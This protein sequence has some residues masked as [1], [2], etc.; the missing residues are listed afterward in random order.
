ML[1]GFKARAL[2]PY[3]AGSWV[4]AFAV[5]DAPARDHL[6]TLYVG[7][8]NGGVWKTVNAGTTFEPIFDGQPKLSIGDV[9]VAPSDPNVV[10]VGTGEPYCARSSNSGD[11]VWKS[12]D[13][14]KTWTNMGLGDTHHI[15]RVVIHPANPDVVYVAAM[16]HLFSEN[17]ERGVFKTADGG[18]SWKKVLYVDDRIGAV[19]LTL[20]KSAP[21]T[22][23]RGDVREGATALDLQPRRTGECHPQD[24]RRREDVDAA[25]GRPADGPDRPD[26]ARRLPEGPERALRGRRERQ[27]AAGDAAGDRAGQAPRRRAGAAHRGQRGLPHGRRRRDLA[28]GQRRLRGG[29]RQGALLLQPAEDRS[30]RQGDRLHH[31]AVPRLDQRRRQDL[32]GPRLAVRRRHAPGLRRLAGD[33]DRSA[34]PGPADL[35]FGRRRQLSPMTGARRATTPTTCR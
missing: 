27:P 2:G 17:A 26:R 7:T 3:R 8:R 14:G 32:E 28:Q 35:R 31:R 4:T 5:P 1:K 18:R 16:G 12:T 20:V 19:D 30:R 22:L 9:A 24:D 33:V 25:R 10:W 23:L 6:Y 13:A 29:P 15:A 34:R 21:D 11:G